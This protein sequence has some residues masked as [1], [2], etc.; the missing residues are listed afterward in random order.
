MCELCGPFK[1]YELLYNIIFRLNLLGVV[2][3]CYVIL[4]RIYF[5]LECLCIRE[6]MKFIGK[7]MMM[8]I[9]IIMFLLLTTQQHVSTIKNPQI[10]PA[11]PTTHVNRINKMTPKIF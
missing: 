2:N 5:L 11:V 4:Q 6:M 3:L 1:R 9:I 8:I 10:A 7:R